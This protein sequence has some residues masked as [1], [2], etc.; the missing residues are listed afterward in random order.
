MLTLS[1]EKPTSQLNYTLHCHF[2]S[3]ASLMWD[4]F[5]I[6]DCLSSIQYIMSA[7]LSLVDERLVLQS[8]VTLQYSVVRATVVIVSQYKFTRCRLSVIN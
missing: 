3:L 1:I 7:C 4:W 6:H 8:S 5:R 2:S